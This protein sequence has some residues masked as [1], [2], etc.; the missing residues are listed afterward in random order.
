MRE[1]VLNHAS[2]GSPDQHT[3]VGWLKEVTVGMTM[4]VRDKIAKS[5]LRMRQSHAEILCLS[6]WSLWDALQELRKGGAR[7][8][9]SFLTRLTT[10]VPLLCDIDQEVA[11]RFRAC[12][13]KTLPPEDGEP[14]V[15]C[16][17][18]DGIAVGFPS[19]PVWD[20]DHLTIHFNELLP[21]ESIG[22]A[23]EMI[24]NLTRF[25]HVQPICE[26]HRAGLRD[27]FTN[28]AALW[29]GKE[30]AFPN[31][32]FG[33]EV[34]GHLSR[35]NDLQLVVKRLASLNES[36]CEWRVIGGTMPPWKSKVTSESEPLMDKPRLREARRFR[37]HRGTRELFEWH[38]R[39]GSGG[40]IHL[41]FE[42]SSR[43][44]EIGYIGPHLPLG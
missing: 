8:E 38:A 13:A 23:S 19:D 29:N 28:A 5:T 14:L 37:S 22:G 12:E 32:I 30:Q 17:I 2:L 24:D 7:D 39:F 26:R 3:A 40:R 42:P 36:A 11:D 44:V 6:N 4:L 27:Q 34:E 20:C 18:T 35:L 16:A 1:M 31:L 21:D 9:Y 41:R 43:E 10:K 15:L 33:P 25:A